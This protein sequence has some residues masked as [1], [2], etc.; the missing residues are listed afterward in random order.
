MTNK[1]KIKSLYKK[2]YKLLHKNLSTHLEQ[3]CHHDEYESSGKTPPDRVPSHAH[4]SARQ[5]IILN[6]YQYQTEKKYMYHDT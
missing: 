2:I 3:K 4:P 1:I 5:I 6:K